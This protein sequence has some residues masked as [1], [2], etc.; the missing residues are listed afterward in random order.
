MWLHAE[1]INTENCSAGIK[2]WTTTCSTMYVHG[3]SKA[4]PW[5]QDRITSIRK[6]FD[7][8][9]RIEMRVDVYG[10]LGF[11]RFSD[12]VWISIGKDVLSQCRITSAQAKNGVI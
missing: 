11:K 2:N 5:N 6:M 7:Y 3:C 8:V 4:W 10:C 9:S 1:R 12:S